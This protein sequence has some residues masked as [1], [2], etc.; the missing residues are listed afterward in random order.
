[1]VAY[2]ALTL[3]GLAAQRAGYRARVCRYRV[4]APWLALRLLYMSQVLKPRLV[5]RALLSYSWS[6]SYRES[7]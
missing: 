4:S 3:I 5:R 7:G 1:M 6:L 2:Y